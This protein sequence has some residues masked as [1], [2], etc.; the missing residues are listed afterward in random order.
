ML[1]IKVMLLLIM[2]IITITKW[3]GRSRTLITTINTEFFVTLHNRWKP[4]TNIKRSSISKDALYV[5]YMSLKRLT[6][7]LTW[8]IR[9]DRA[10]RMLCLELSPTWFCKDACK[11]NINL[12]H[13]NCS[14]NNNNNNNNNNTWLLDWD[15]QYEDPQK[16][17]TKKITRNTKNIYIFIVRIQNIHH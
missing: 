8:W 17:R 1:V 14:N 15:K 3:R 5:L 4:L 11:G 6:H 16:K 13:H 9:V 7:H 12:R 10:A 2:I